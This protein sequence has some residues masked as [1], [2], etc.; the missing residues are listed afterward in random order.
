MVIKI[1]ND[2]LFESVHTEVNFLTPDTIEIIYTDG[3]RRE[4]LVAVGK[5]REDDFLNTFGFKIIG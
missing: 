2:K 3:E 1:V 5:H 4:R